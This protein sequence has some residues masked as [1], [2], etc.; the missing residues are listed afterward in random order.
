MLFTK[1][2]H[3]NCT[4]LEDGEHVYCDHISFSEDPLKR[5]V[6]V[7]RLKEGKYELTEN[8]FLFDNKLYSFEIA[9]V[10]NSV[11]TSNYS[12]A[13]C[14]DFFYNTMLIVT[15]I[16]ITFSII[17]STS[18]I[19]SE[20]SSGTVKLLL[21]RPY[22]RSKILT[23][24]IVASIIFSSF[25]IILSA[26]VC[27]I[28]GAIL[29]PSVVALNPVLVVISASSAFLINPIWLSIL[30]LIATLIKCSIYIL[31][32]ILIS[33]LFRNPIASIVVALSF[34]FAGLICNLFISSYAWAMLLP[35]ANFDL[36][37][38]FLP[39]STSSQIGNL[40]TGNYTLTNIFISIIYDIIVTSIL[41]L[42]S[43]YIFKHN[44]I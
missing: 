33:S 36:F 8:R 12:T 38:Y 11:S 40:F 5:S 26:I 42:P 30:F 7:I 14:F 28:I 25:F 17:L 39:L 37:N 19:A 23:A 21:I 2:Y 6:E 29:F 10:F 4:L 24:K 44:D 1:E 13:T 34:Y 15:A 16:I 43:Y 20:Y 18:T 27:F 22:S 3:P 41:M 35:F 31:I 9:H 32:S